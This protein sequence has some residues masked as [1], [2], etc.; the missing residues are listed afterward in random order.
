MIKHLLERQLMN[1]EGIVVRANVR[2]LP[3]TEGGR[4]APIRGSYRP[5]HNLFGPDNRQMTTGFID[6]PD[7]IELCPGGESAEVLVTF[8]RWPGLDS[9]IYS[10]REWRIQEG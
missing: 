8:W 5:N 10:G 1:K 3:T 2:L 7:G 9:Q 4:T 6:L